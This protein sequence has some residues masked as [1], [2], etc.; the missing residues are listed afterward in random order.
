MM[1]EMMAEYL[2][3]GM[4]DWMVVMLVGEKGSTTVAL[5]VLLWVAAMVMQL[6][7]LMVLPWAVH[8]VS[9]MVDM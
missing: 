9:S 3:Y 1:V 5:M 7:A 2:A 4:A 6:V 8:W